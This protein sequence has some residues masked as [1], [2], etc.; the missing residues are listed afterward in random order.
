[1]DIHTSR[2]TDGQTDRQTDHVTVTYVAIAG[3]ALMT[4]SAV[5]PNNTTA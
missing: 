1:M 2:R 4:L 5:P 3:L